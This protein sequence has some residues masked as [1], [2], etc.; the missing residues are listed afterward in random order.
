MKEE[1][2]TVKEESV[3]EKP[4]KKKSFFWVILLLFFLLI[5]SCFISLRSWLQPPGGRTNFLVL[6]VTG[7]DNFGGDLTDTMIYVSLDNQTGKVTLVSLP[8]DIWIPDLKIKI[9]A[10][11]HYGGF[12]MVKKTV[13]GITGQS[14][15]YALLID[16]NLF[17]KIIDFLGGVDI[18]VKTGF[19]DKNYPIVG[20]ENDLCNGDKELKCRYEDLIFQA[21]WQ[22]MD[23]ERALKYV[24]SRYSSGD[25]GTDFARSKRQENLILAL[26]NKI[27]SWD[28]LS[29]PQK[30]R[31]LINMILENIKTDVPQ[32]KYWDLAKTGFRFRSDK[33]TTGVIS[34][35]FLINP[36][37]SKTYDN[38]WVL[39]PKDNNWSE[40]Q[41]Y[42]RCLED[43]SPCQN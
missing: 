1:K 19:E 28:F 15:D 27:L 17:V 12:E 8:R 31:Q 7:H 21:G 40:V 3:S 18:N 29:H 11:Y 24:R 20:R 37:I 13:S 16:S 10:A 43:G 9:N 32:N 38:L 35:S 2:E 5:T 41:K 26:K 6:G 42:I 30:S 4:Q 34:D 33:L 23:G 22:R 36:K 25:E 39:I 14:V